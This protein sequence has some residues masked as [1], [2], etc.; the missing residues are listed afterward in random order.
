MAQV[1]LIAPNFKVDEVNVN[2]MI[3]EKESYFRAL[4][5]AIETG[6]PLTNVEVTNTTDMRCIDPT[7]IVGTVSEYLYEND[8]LTLFVDVDGELP[9]GA[10]AFACAIAKQIDRVHIIEELCC[11]TT[12]GIPHWHAPHKGE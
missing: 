7:T 2:G 9:D 10:M 12:E 3:L 5:N 1:K 11:F 8:R 4:D 6:L